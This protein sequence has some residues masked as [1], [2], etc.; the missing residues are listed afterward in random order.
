MS[1]SPS[2]V[3]PHSAATPRGAHRRWTAAAGAHV[4]AYLCSPSPWC[5]RLATQ[6]TALAG[7]C[8][9]RAASG[10]WGAW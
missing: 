5:A 10:A 1:S 4:C 8:W 6:H 3:P 2:S 9:I 7:T